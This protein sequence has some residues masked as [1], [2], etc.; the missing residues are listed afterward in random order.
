MGGGS[1]AYP[2]Q[3]PPNTQKGKE[4]QKGGMVHGIINL[5]NTDVGPKRGTGSGMFLVILASVKKGENGVA[6]MQDKK[7]L[8]V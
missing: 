7:E 3:S 1:R 5:P 6:T 2:F 4:Q 8:S